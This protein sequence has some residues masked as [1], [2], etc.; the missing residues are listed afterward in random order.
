LFIAVTF[1]APGTLTHPPSVRH[2]QLCTY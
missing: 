1:R 2:W